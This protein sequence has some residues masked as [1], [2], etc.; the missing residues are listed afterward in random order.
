MF[1][2]TYEAWWAVRP[3]QVLQQDDNR[4]LTGPALR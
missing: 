4:K 3:T 2:P 1:T